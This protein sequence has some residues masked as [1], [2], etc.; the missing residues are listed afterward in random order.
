MLI[1]NIFKKNLMYPLECLHVPPGLRVPP[2]ENHWDRACL[3]LGPFTHTWT[4]KLWTFASLQLQPVRARRR[5]KHLLPRARQIISRLYV[6]L[7]LTE[8]WPVIFTSHSPMCGRALMLDVFNDYWYLINQFGIMAHEL[9]N[10]NL[11]NFSHIVKT[12]PN[13]KV[14]VLIT[15][16]IQ[17]FQVVYVD[18][19]QINSLINYRAKMY[20]CYGNSGLLAMPVFSHR[21]SLCSCGVS[22]VSPPQ[23][24][25]SEGSAAQTPLAANTGVLALAGAQAG[26]GVG[27][28]CP[29]GYCTGGYGTS[30][31]SCARA[32]FVRLITVTVPESMLRAVA[33]ACN[34]ATKTRRAPSAHGHA[35]ATCVS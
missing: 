19:R 26:D 30:G 23:I 21:S 34:V 29:S 24:Q 25:P 16:L 35:H 17:V 12:P 13:N 5:I 4:Y 32:S 20:I 11:R 1:L 31:H 22:L 14:C 8:L 33:P 28:D 10:L 9:I 3:Y 15:V 6:E 18:Y 7:N 2:F 27:D